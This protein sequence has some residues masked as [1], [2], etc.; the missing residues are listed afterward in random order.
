[1]EPM[2]MMLRVKEAAAV[3]LKSRG[4]YYC[5]LNV[6]PVQSTPATN[7]VI[8]QEERVTTNERP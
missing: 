7:R 5:C 6:V 8:S 3:S 1:M 4:Y 2:P